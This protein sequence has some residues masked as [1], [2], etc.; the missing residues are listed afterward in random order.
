MLSLLPFFLQ[1]SLIAV[2]SLDKYLHSSQESLLEWK[3]KSEAQDGEL[4][5]ARST[6]TALRARNQELEER[7]VRHDA[8]LFDALKRQEVLEAKSS[9]YDQLRS[10]VDIGQARIDE[11]TS[12]VLRFDAANSGLR[13]KVADLRA[14][15]A[16]SLQSE[17]E[18][19]VC[20]SRMQGVID[21]QKGL[22]AGFKAEV[23]DLSRNLRSVEGERT[24]ARNRLEA[25]EER[26]ALLGAEMATLKKAIGELLDQEKAATQLADRVVENNCEVTQLAR[27]YKNQL[28][29]VHVIRNRTWV[30]EFKWGFETLRSMAANEKLKSEVPTIKID[31]IRPDTRALGELRSIGVAELPDAISMGTVPPPIARVRREARGKPGAGPSAVSRV[32]GER[33]AEPSTDRSAPSS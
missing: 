8:E 28:N 1:G 19:Q 20:S 16:R 18:L 14:E 26:L 15:L 24:S 11:L 31:D 12:D 9:K 17:S 29:T 30:H 33:G 32:G 6:I 3:R 5:A 22:I 13:S 2:N 4:A 25:A 7:S 27:R 10:A 23:S 21:E